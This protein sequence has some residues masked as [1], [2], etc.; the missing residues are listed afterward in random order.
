MFKKTG[1]FA[2]MGEDAVERGHQSGARAERRVGGMADLEKK[3]R[4]IISYEGMEKHPRVNEK[5][6]EIFAGTKRNF[7]KPRESAE[8]RSEKAGQERDEQRKALLEFPLEVG[9]METLRDRK[10]SRTDQALR[11]PTGR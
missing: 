11:D 3:A 9:Q 2:E 5:Q 6:A 7:T 8:D 10:K 1:G 4:S